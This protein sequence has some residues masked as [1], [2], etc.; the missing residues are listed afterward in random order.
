MLLVR[1]SS[2]MSYFNY[3]RTFVAVYRCGSH[4]KASEYLGMTQP[5]IS[6]QIATLEAKIGKP[7][8]HK[9]G[10][11]RFKAT[12]AGES[13]A[14]E[15]APHVDRIEE[16]FNLTKH[17]TNAVS[18][19]VYIGGLSE[20]IEVYLSDVIASL[21]PQEIAFIIQ[22]ETG[23]D[24]QQL[25]E[26]HSLDMAIMP[27]S[28]HS[29]SIGCRELLSEEMVMVAT[30]KLCGEL[31]IEELYGIP[32]IAHFEREIST[33]H[34]LKMMQLEKA[35]FKRGA[36]VTSFRMMK[37]LLMSSAGFSI[38]PRSMVEKEIAEGSLKII[39]LPITIPPLRLFLVWN[40]FAIQHA[41]QRFVRDAIFNR[42]AAS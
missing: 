29:P 6:K 8:F 7:L 34:Y 28:C 3:L 41:R 37:E 4:S 21:I 11:Q 2:C 33:A 12:T 35:S 18:G 10:E 31:S 14:S 39:K 30:T 25:L 24:C 36:T 40:N 17:G 13:L 9:T 23:R 5:A 16:I 38:I 27:K 1:E 26:N 19:T 32:Y 42:L 15:L 20:F 22:D